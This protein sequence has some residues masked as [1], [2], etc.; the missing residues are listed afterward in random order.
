MS[1]DCLIDET[2]AEE[3]SGHNNTGVITDEAFTIPEEAE[4]IQTLN[5]HLLP[6]F[7]QHMILSTET[8][9]RAKGNEQK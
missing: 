8:R 9:K 5:G 1:S 3:R 7:L 2:I 4:S 6:K